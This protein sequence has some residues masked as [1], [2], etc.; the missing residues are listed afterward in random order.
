MGVCGRILGV[1]HCF[2]TAGYGE[3]KLG[4]GKN[5]RFIGGD[6]GL[7]RGQPSAR[8]PYKVGVLCS[9]SQD[10]DKQSFYNL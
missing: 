10:N 9:R 3:H 2:T 4:D 5:A 8:P 1:R 7:A 6:G